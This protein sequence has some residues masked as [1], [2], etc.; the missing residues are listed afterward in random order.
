MKTQTNPVEK[1]VEEISTN[2]SKIIDDFI[3]T[4]I[5]VRLDWFREK[6]ERLTKLELV[7]RIS[8]DQMTRT[9]TLQVKSG[10][11]KNEK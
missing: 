7:E 10:K 4:Y 11:Y 1:L 8:G 2:K 5:A 3:K 9:Y 6:P